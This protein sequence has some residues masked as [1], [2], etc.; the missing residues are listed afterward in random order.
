MSILSKLIFDF[1]DA[2]FGVDALRVR[3]T[4]WLPE[5]A[6]V[7]EAPEWVVGLFNLRGQIVPVVDLGRRLHH[8]PRPCRITDQVVVLEFDDRLIGLIVSEVREVIEIDASAIQRPP[9]FVAASGQITHLIAGEARVGAEIV[10]LLD[11]AQLLHP[12]FEPSL[13]EDSTQTHAT[14]HFCPQASPEERALFRHRANLLGASLV[15]EAGDRIGLAVVELDG[16]FFGVELSAVREFCDMTQLTPIPC[17][18]PHILGVISLRG[19][20]LTLLDPG[21]AL[22]LSATPRAGGK[23]VVS[24]I[25]EQAVGVAVDAVHDIVYPRQ[26][27]LLTAPPQLR[28]RHGAEI[29]GTLTWEGQMMAVLDLPA[30]LSRDEWVVDASGDH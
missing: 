28:E 10:A 26:D 6:P 13:P 24:S 11:V 1:D 22:N 9:Q 17:C 2:L 30:L 25:G 4:L 12:S 14:G 8:P 3:E 19:N 16:E 21:A 15:T 27:A 18:P 20:L 29:K 5:L 23:V 7:E